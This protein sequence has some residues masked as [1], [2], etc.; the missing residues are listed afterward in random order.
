MENTYWCH[1]E[2]SCTL[3]NQ[4]NTCGI[5]GHCVDAVK[6][7]KEYERIFDKYEDEICGSPDEQ[8]I[9][10]VNNGISKYRRGIK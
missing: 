7:D 9:R 1:S 10:G 4:D 2:H 6:R 5:D 3:R 8:T